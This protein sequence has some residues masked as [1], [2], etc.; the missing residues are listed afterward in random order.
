MGEMQNQK[1]VFNLL[2]CY[3]VV[4]V[5][6]KKLFLNAYPEYKP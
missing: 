6:L 4:S 2:F 3:I 1:T 5:D